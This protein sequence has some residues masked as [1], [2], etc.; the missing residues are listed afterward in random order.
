MENIFIPQ[1]SGI[2]REKV[3]LNQGDYCF[4]G[5]VNSSHKE[6][7]NLHTSGFMTWTLTE[8]EQDQMFR[9]QVISGKDTSQKKTQKSTPDIVADL[10]TNRLFPGVSMGRQIFAELEQYGR[11]ITGNTT[12]EET[13]VLIGE[14][15]NLDMPES[16]MHM[17]SVDMIRE[18]DTHVNVELHDDRTVIDFFMQEDEYVDDI[19]DKLS[20]QQLESPVTASFFE[21]S[22]RNITLEKKKKS[23]MTKMIPINLSR[24]QRIYPESMRDMLARDVKLEYGEQEWLEPYI[25]WETSAG[26]VELNGKLFRLNEPPLLALRKKRGRQRVFFHFGYDLATRVIDKGFS[27]LCPVNICMTIPVGG[28]LG[29]S[30]QRQRKIIT[31][32][33]IFHVTSEDIDKMI[34]VFSRRKFVFCEFWHPIYEKVDVFV[35]R[36]GEIKEYQARKFKSRT[37]RQLYIPEE[38]EKYKKGG[39]MEEEFELGLVYVSSELP[40]Q[41]EMHVQLRLWYEFSVA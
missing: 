6:E 11:V 25:H 17:F 41:T 37:I 7:G 28:N 22:I 35:S 40:M 5:G 39:R 23:S 10:V 26:L 3:A 8:E 16:E 15:G 2:I 1:W 21:D 12:E 4:L 13:T 32:R 30:R 20:E 27:F 36:P 38:S 18:G 19:I 9:C 31:G 29:K 33:R 34:R 14:Q 24:L